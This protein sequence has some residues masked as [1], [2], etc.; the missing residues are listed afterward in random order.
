[1]REVLPVIQLFA[2]GLPRNQMPQIPDTRWLEWWLYE[3][4]YSY[5]YQLVVAES[6]EPMQSELNLELV[7]KIIAEGLD[8]KDRLL[9]VA[10]NKVLDGHNR[11]YAGE[12]LRESVWCIVIDTVAE[13]LLPLLQ[14]AF[15]ERESI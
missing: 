5:N 13:E 1:M 12:I 3:H 6:L 4:G 7:V 10:G 14:V 8:T 11:W 2:G 9:V 15:P